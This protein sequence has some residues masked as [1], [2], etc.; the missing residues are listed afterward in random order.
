MDPPRSDFSVSMRAA[1]NFG[2]PDTPGDDGGAAASVSDINLNEGGSP[3][4]SPQSNFSPREQP[5]AQGPQ[6]PG[7]FASTVQDAAASQTGAAAPAHSGKTEG[8]KTH[9]VKEVLGMNKKSTKG[10][11]DAEKEQVELAQRWKNALE[12]EK[13]LNDLEQHVV[14]GE[15]ATAR[16][17][18]QPNFPPKFLC[19]KPLVYHNIAALP[20][21]RQRM[22]TVAYYNWIAVCVLLVVN[23]GVSIGVGFAPFRADLVEPVEFNKGLN[24]VLAIVYL[25]GIP[26]SFIFWYWRVYTACSTGRPGEHIVALFGL[27]VAFAWALFAFAGPVSYGVSGI[28]LAVHIG[29]TRARGVVAPVA[30]VLVMWLC[31]AGL[32]GYL[33]VMQFLYYRRDLNARRLARRRAAPVLG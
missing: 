29:K 20:A 15:Q 4:E 27:I 21:S 22:V 23:M 3:T 10:M 18:E 33:I 7:V 5:S 14:A 32:V 16:V 12:E 30:V 8:K 2:D 24:T 19:L 28:A 6:S 25:I 31:E 26:L 13:R 11:T 17:V 1:Y 9:I